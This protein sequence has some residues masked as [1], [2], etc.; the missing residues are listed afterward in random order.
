MKM[1]SDFLRLTSELFDVKRWTEALTDGFTETD[2]LDER[3]T[4]S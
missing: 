1:I 4:S 3:T 2:S